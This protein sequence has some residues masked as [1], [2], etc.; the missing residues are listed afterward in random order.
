MITIPFADSRAPSNSPSAAES[1]HR[2]T[3]KGSDR[4]KAFSSSLSSL[5]GSDPKPR[6]R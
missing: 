4:L 6:H 3:D 1:R 2:K 5:F